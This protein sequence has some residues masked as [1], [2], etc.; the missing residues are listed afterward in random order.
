MAIKALVRTL[1]EIYGLLIK[2]IKS[3]SGPRRKHN[4]LICSK[5]R[6]LYSMVSSRVNPAWIVNY[7]ARNTSLLP[8]P[9][10]HP[11]PLLPKT[12]SPKTMLKRW[13]E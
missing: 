7:L 4:I 8:P 9:T 10:S 2:R 11:S 6:T 1:K 13:E 3:T 12:Y 5:T